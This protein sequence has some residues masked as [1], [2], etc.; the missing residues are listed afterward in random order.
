MRTLSEEAGISMA[1]LAIYWAANQPGITCAISGVRSA[2]Q[3][4]DALAGANLTPPQDLM[5][6]LTELSEPVK[7]KL[8]AN[9]DYFQSSENSRTH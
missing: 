1:Q 6:R 8:G 4:R 7:S 9:A 2:A 3:L 5:Q